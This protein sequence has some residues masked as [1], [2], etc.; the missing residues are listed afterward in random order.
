[1]EI[2][3]NLVISPYLPYL[4]AKKDDDSFYC[5]WIE[6]KK[7]ESSYNVVFPDYTRGCVN[8][9]DI[10]W[11]GFYSLPSHPWPKSPTDFP[12]GFP[13]KQPGEIK[14]EKEG[15]D[16]MSSTHEAE[17][18]KFFANTP[19]ERQKQILRYNNEQSC[20]CKHCLRYTQNVA[21]FGETGEQ[22]GKFHTTPTRSSVLRLNKKALCAETS[23]NGHSSNER[24]DSWPNNRY[25][26]SNVIGKYIA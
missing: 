11:L 9:K 7:N 12:L 10:I 24:T 17:L 26:K 20:Y 8:E 3:R 15:V 16:K 5:A 19:L 2:S 13:P 6:D 18:L 14:I 23:K 22:K 25:A 21:C 4:Y 1:M